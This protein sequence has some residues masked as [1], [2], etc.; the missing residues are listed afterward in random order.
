MHLW[1]WNCLIQRIKL[2]QLSK[3]KPLKHAMFVVID[4][5]IH[6]DKYNYLYKTAL[7]NELT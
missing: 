2:K 4:I 3:N 6:V 7:F 1:V 5:E